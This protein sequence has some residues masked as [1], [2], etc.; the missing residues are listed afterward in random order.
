MER[1]CHGKIV[2]KDVKYMPSASTDCG[3][4]GRRSEWQE[5]ILDRKHLHS[6]FCEC[7]V[8]IYQ[9]LA[10]CVVKSPHFYILY[11]KSSSRNT[12]VTA[13]LD[14]KQMSLP[15]ISATMISYIGDRLLAIFYSLKNY[16]HI[17][18]AHVRKRLFRS[19]Q[20]KI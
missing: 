13:V 14:R 3:N 9:K 1:K 5:H 16:K 15:S 7:T 19:F 10:Y 18:T 12:T 20:S 11:K 6:R 8:K 4:R 2:H 17:L